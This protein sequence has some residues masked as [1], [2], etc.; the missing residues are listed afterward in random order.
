MIA[1][2]S[3]I[4]REV[5]ALLITPAV[6]KLFPKVVAIAPAGATAMDTL[7]PIIVKSTHTGL[8]PISI[9]TGT[10][11]SSLVYLLVPAFLWF[12]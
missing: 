5:I 12:I 1:L 10:V 9:L 11:L 2:L 8:T 3:N 4:I 7:L 6:P